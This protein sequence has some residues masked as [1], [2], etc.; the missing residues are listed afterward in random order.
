MLS[1]CLSPTSGRLT[2]YHR[3]A[4]TSCDLNHR[5][6]EAFRASR[7]SCPR[8]LKV[9]IPKFGS[10][11][12][13]QRRK[14][15]LTSKATRSRLQRKSLF[16]SLI[17]SFWPSVAWPISCKQEISVQSIIQN[18]NFTI[19]LGTTSIDR[20]SP[21]PTCLAWK[22]IWTSREINWPWS[23]PFMR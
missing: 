5:L 3:H 9:G 23:I 18:T 11:C 20:I 7:L 14:L 10:R 2:I 6:I 8:K 13:L 1:G 12:L 21:R 16:S 15:S 17:S 22:R 4:A 19:L